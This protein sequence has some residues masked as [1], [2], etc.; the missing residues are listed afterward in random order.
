[1]TEANKY[2]MAQEGQLPEVKTPLTLVAP[3]I[4]IQK[5]K[6]VIL[7]LFERVQF[8]EGSVVSDKYKFVGS[9]YTG[10]NTKETASEI[11][12]ILKAQF[13]EIKFS[14]T[15]DY[16]SIS[17]TIK[18]S[19]YNCSKLEYSADLEPREY[20]EFE[21]EH[22][23]ELKAIGEYCKALLTSYNFDDSDIYEDY[24]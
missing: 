21:A 7:P 24:S 19:P 6:K 10:L 9:N 23:K 4:K 1:M 8:I 20:R 14:T 5:G 12:K 3:A 16:S 2:I 22:N 17:V 11:R 18:Q 13:P 15:S